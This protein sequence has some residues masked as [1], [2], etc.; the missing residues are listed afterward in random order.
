MIDACLEVI[1]QTKKWSA[2]S[3]QLTCFQQLE[4]LYYLRFWKWFELDYDKIK[5]ILC[6][7]KCI[8][9][10]FNVQIIC[11]SLAEFSNHMSIRILY[12]LLPF[13]QCHAIFKE[14]YSFIQ[15]FSRREYISYCKT[16]SQLNVVNQCSFWPCLK[17]F[18]KTHAQ[19]IILICFDL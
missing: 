4:L 10:E 2:I 8:S 14:N 6:K 5:L 12:P 13:C 1:C 7:T 19:P 9:I 17:K 15:N 18:A 3:R 16:G 11:L